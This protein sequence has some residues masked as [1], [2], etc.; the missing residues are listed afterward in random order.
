MQELKKKGLLPPG[1]ELPKYEL[2]DV[3][4]VGAHV[5]S[6][7]IHLTAHIPS[8]S[9]SMQ[10]QTFDPATHAFACWE[11]FNEDGKAAVG[12]LFKNSSTL[13]VR[14]NTMAQ[15][16]HSKITHCCALCNH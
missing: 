16:A 15:L 11:G 13:K 3:A 12:Q 2:C 5:E 14:R 7:Y 6:P 8:T 9:S 1:A 4:E 10:M